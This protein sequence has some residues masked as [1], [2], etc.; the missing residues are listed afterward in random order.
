MIEL[1]NDSPWSVAACP[2][3][4]RQRRSCV[5]IIV[6][7]AWRFDTDGATEPLDP[8][9]A[10]E[11]RDRFA[12]DPSSSSVIAA[13]EVAP[14]KR[15]GEI[16]LFGTVWPARSGATSM[17]VLLGLERDGQAWE[18]RLIVHGERRW[19]RGLF[20]LQADP[21]RELQSVPL[22]YEQAWGGRDPD[23]D[24]DVC[25]GNPAGKGHA[26]RAR[27]L[28]GRPL[29]AIEYPGQSLPRPGQPL[30]PAGFGPLPVHW[31]PRASLRAAFDIQAARHGAC[32]Y[33]DSVDEALHNCAPPD[34]RFDAP[35]TGDETV[36]LQGFFKGH[37][38]PVRV[39]VPFVVPQI[40]ATAPDEPPAAV[41][42]TLVVDTD[43]RQVQRI[44][45]TRILHSRTESRITDVV[46]TRPCAAGEVREPL[47][48]YA[49]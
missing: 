37:P 36:V 35:F 41:C 39:P 40:V 20:G 7:Q 34:Q 21:A 27:L 31:E 33:P 42:D 12:A 30:R 24:L 2:G 26:R 43:L 49:V 16:Y 9:P 29:P 19:R 25:P 32:P 11:W 38:G 46:V 5:T 3:W 47:Q 23:N 28:D 10:V 48:E 14:F 44:W 17:E 8:V 6:K 1:H 18:K 13:S 15:G 45:R 4:D 22:R